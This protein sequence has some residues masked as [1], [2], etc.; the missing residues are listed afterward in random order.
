[1]LKN[2]NGL[3]TRDFYR[4]FVK[5]D[6]K[7]LNKDGFEVSGGERSEFNL[8]QEIQDAQRYDMLLIDEPESSFDNLFLKNEVNQLIKDISKTMPVVLVTHNSTVGA[9]IKPDYMLYTKKEVV[10]GKIQYRIYSGA[11]SS[12][13]LTSTKGEN[14]STWDATM[15]C[16]EAGED[17]YNE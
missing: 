3:E 7:V 9:S 6:Y 11:P 12:I 15:G 17:A 10:D 5:I 13:K 1:E 16:L 2:I 4:Y 14:L 8:L